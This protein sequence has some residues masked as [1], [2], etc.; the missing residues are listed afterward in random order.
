MAL[1]VIRDSGP[2]L[3][4][5]LRNMQVVV[6]GYG[7]QG[8][9]HALNLRDSGVDVVVGSRPQ[10]NGTRQAKL[11]G[12]APLPIAEAAAKADLVILALPDEVQPEL[13][14][15]DI[16]PHLKPDAVIG[17]IHGFAIRYELIKP[18]ASRGVVMIAPKGP[19]T[20]LRQRYVEGTGIPCLLAIAQESKNNT[21]EQLALAWA[22]GIGCARAGIIRTTF[23]D[24]TESDLFGEQAV[25][26]GGLTWLVLTAF[27]TLVEA[28]YEPELAYIECCHEVK[29]IADLV[30]SRGVNGMMAAISNTAEFGAHTA[31]ATLIDDAVRGRMKTILAEIRSGDFAK[32]MRDD[33]DNGF[34]WFNAQRR[35]LQKHPIDN[36]GKAVRDLMPWLNADSSNA[37]D[38]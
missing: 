4:E 27:E 28:G 5:P 34:E 35:A 15:T 12:F 9:A 38:T 25:L 21:A 22:A 11:D 23:A 8:R 2:S 16:A 26:C 14:R 17:F 19:G 7:N 33:Y 30:Y 18:E 13:W 1:E 32:R 6:A 29:Q 31:G 24:E 20:T 10:A 36:A 37:A 3:M